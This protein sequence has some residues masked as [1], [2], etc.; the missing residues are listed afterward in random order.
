MPQNQNNNS[1]L[2]N[3]VN[4]GRLFLRKESTSPISVDF[5]IDTDKEKIYIYICRGR[6]TGEGLIKR[7]KNGI[8]LETKELISFLRFLIAMLEEI[9]IDI[10][11]EEEPNT[12]EAYAKAKALLESANTKE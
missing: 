2:K 11:S 6:P 4:L 10:F 8:R 1:Y 7:T 9:G 5:G 12:K 3:L